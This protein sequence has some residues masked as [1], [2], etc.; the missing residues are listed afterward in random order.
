MSLFLSCKN[1]VFNP[2]WRIPST[3]S[4]MRKVVQS[5]S[6]MCTSMKYHRFSTE[7][8]R[9]QSPHSLEHVNKISSKPYDI[10]VPFIENYRARWPQPEIFEANEEIVLPKRTVPDEFMTFRMTATMDHG[11]AIHYP[12]LAYNPADFKVILLVSHDL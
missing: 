10:A 1:L 4:N 6:K 8:K 7:V 12:H 2:V 11:Q 9:V 3:A 5:V